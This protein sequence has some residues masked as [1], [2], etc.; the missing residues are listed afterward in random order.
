[1]HPF[2]ETI[3]VAGAVAATI[4]ATVLALTLFY[5]GLAWVTS[6]AKR[7]IIAVRGVLG[8]DAL[9]DVTVTLGR[10]PQSSRFDTPGP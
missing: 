7:D 4:V 9:A 5:R 6:G 1:M 8:K 10:R 3:S 2:A